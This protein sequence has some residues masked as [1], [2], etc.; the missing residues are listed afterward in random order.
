MNLAIVES[1]IVVFIGQIVHFRMYT[2]TKDYLPYKIAFFMRLEKYQ[3]LSQNSFFGLQIL[4]ILE[5]TSQ[6]VLEPK[7]L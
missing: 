1:T 4:E 3:D 6:E 7:F 5:N 2:P